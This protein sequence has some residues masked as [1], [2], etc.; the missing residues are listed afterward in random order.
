MNFSAIG[1][2]SNI[3]SETFAGPSAA[4]ELE[5]QALSRFI[6]SFAGQ[7]KIYL[8]FHSYGQYFLFPYGHSADNST[9]YDAQV[10]EGMLLI[11]LVVYCLISFCS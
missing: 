1:A 5:T 8:A 7:T 6:A 4:S 2:S 9:H 3:C 10:N 11:T